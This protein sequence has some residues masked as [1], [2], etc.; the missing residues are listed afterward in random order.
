MARRE[1]RNLVHRQ[2]L[3]PERGFRP[4]ERG[5]LRYNSEQMDFEQRLVDVPSRVAPP[6]K[7]NSGWFANF[8]VEG[9]G[10]AGDVSRNSTGS[11]K[12]C[13]YD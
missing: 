11:E 8:G 9:K 3:R 10:T 13:P 6:R 12:E 5:N 7:S 2:K 4:S 1:S